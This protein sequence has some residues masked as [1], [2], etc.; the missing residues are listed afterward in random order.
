MIEEND[1]HFEWFD[2]LIGGLHSR[3]PHAPLTQSV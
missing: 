1:I 2:L 3:V